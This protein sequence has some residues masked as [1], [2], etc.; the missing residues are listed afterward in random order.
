MALLTS[1]K[2]LLIAFGALLL[3]GCM[4]S[5]IYYYGIPGVYTPEHRRPTPM[6]IAANGIASPLVLNAEQ[7][8]IYKH[9]IAA[10][11]KRDWQK[12]DALMA[13]VKNRVLIGHLLARRYLHSA[14]KPTSI[15]LTGWLDR[16]G[17][18]PQA[19]EIF[20]KLDDELQ[21]HMDTPIAFERLKENKQRSRIPNQTSKRY[22]GAWAYQAAGKQAGILRQLASQ[23]QQKIGKNA[24][25]DISPWINEK[26]RSNHLSTATH[27]LLRFYAG[28]HYFSRGQ[29]AQAYHMAQAAAT[30]SGKQ[31]PSLDWLAGMAAWQQGAPILAARHF[32]LMADRMP[33]AKHI[34]GAAAAFWAARAFEKTGESSQAAHYLEQAASNPTHFY[35]ML[36]ASQTN[37]PLQLSNASRMAAPAWQEWLTHDAIKRAAALT[38]LNLRNAAKR[39][40]THAFNT[41][42]KE[43]KLAVMGASMALRYTALAQSMQHQFAPEQT[44]FWWMTL[45]VPEWKP[46]DGWRLPKALVLGVA[47]HESAMNANVKSPAGAQGLMQL[48]PLTA[49][50][51]ANLKGWAALPGS[52]SMQL[53]NPE[54]NMT[55]GQRYLHYLAAQPEVGGNLI[56]MLAA[57]NAGPAPIA[58]WLKAHKADVDP[59]TF[60]ETIPYAETRAYVQQTLMLYWA[61]NARLN[62]PQESLTALA[63]AQWPSLN[64]ST[65]TAFKL[66]KDQRTQ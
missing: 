12:A 62:G 63:E 14:Y 24:N 46:H 43:D 45:P 48:M 56:A 54:T 65:D 66:N 38:Q 26:A 59:L 15:E 53:N 34:D 50:A 22:W 10:Q 57:Y 51:M 20:A 31:L 2:K 9:I 39:H 58:D 17:D 30:R 47:Q 25:D 27:D 33:A 64:E 40:L 5:Y 36:A 23:A 19:A 41:G 42:D 32:A 44:A 61:Y 4:A 21:A 13:T 6:A 35:G 7:K 60:I 29:Y 49:S 28:W 3:E 1:R 55:L 18:H 52:V 37:H 8:E 11:K 16:Y